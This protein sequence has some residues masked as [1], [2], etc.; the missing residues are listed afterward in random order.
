MEL[1]SPEG[2]R[3]DGRRPRELRAIK[4]SMGV[5]GRPDGSAYFQQGNTKVV[6]SVY[7]PNEVG[8]RGDADKSA[9]R[10]FCEYSMAAFSTGERKRRTKGDRR[11]TEIS[12]IM[13]QTF[14]SAIMT[15]LF[16]NSQINI[17]VQIIQADGGTRCAAINAATLALVDAGI[18]L[19][20]MVAAV[21]VGYIDE[22]PVLDLNYVEDSSGRG[23]DIP[24]A[25]FA[26]SRRISMLQVR[27]CCG[28]LCLCLS[29]PR[30][31]LLASFP[32]LPCP[33]SLVPSPLLPPFCAPL[34]FSS[35]CVFFAQPSMHI[36]AVCLC[37]NID[38]S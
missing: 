17:F 20:E 36:S 2:L 13:R 8:R 27:G 28:M 10:V 29:P 22:T 15:E 3:I 26:S 16:P 21:A 34:H 7:G 11:G 38:G 12:L 5:F 33:L 30:S 32:P 25:M 18:P 6:A 23:P 35:R 37:E 14:E 31:P 1:L 24:V 4:C 9:A 19:R